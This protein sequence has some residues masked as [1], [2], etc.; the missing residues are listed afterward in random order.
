M[1]MHRGGGQPVADHD[2]EL[3]CASLAPCQQLRGRLIEPPPEVGTPQ[4]IAAI[5]GAAFDLDG[6]NAETGKL[7]DQRLRLEAGMNGIARPR[8]IE[9]EVEQ[10]P[11]GQARTGAAERDAR[12]GQGPKVERRARRRGLRIIR[13]ERRPRAAESNSSTRS[14]GRRKPRART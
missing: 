11:R 10:R 9:R 6:C 12:R 3:A 13:Q 14:A 8:V 1:R 5:A 2:R 7:R 4:V